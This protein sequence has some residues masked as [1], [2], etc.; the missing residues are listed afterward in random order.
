LDVTRTP[1]VCAVLP[2]WVLASLSACRGPRT[3]SSEAA[4]P[5]AVAATPAATDSR[6]PRIVCL[7]DSLTAG[8]GLEPREAWPALLQARLRT[9]GYDYEI[10]NAGVSGDTTAG[11]L[12]RLEW[13]LD[14]DVRILVVALGANDGLR[15]Q[16]IAEMKRNLERVVR[17][18]QARGITVLLAGMEV[19][20]NFGQAYAA[21]FR[22]AFRDLARERGVAFLP[23]LLAGVAGDP[24][25]NQ[26]D[27][28]HPNAVGTKM[29]AENVWQGLRPLL[30]AARRKRS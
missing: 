21:S 5:I 12:R 30:E 4:A 13:S 9:A 3:S 24:A 10:V 26:G 22:R 11:G 25:L 18:A 14:G 17:G 29:V 16:S 7:G 6:R 19:P 1:V 28:I 20:S 23:F 27:S 8:Y 15:G 2:V